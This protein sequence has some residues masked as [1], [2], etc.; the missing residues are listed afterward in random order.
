MRAEKLEE[1]E[2]RRGRQEKKSR[3]LPISDAF[4]RL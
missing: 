3:G 1:D 2:E 4:G